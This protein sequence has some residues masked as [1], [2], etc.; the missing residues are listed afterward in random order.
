[1]CSPEPSHP[2]WRFFAALPVAAFALNWLWEIVQ[3]PAYEPPAQASAST[4]LAHVVP[5]LGDVALTF[6]V[7]GV[8]ALAAGRWRLARTWNEYAAAVL[9]G[10][11][12]AVAYEWKALASSWWS[13]SSR[14]P[15]VPLLGVG[16]WPVLQLALLVPLAFWLAAWWSSRR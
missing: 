16:L 14:M 2:K 4:A 13:Y 8:C 7:Y 1:M 6:A 5:S 15:V 3:M 9:L 10:G 12:C 11:A